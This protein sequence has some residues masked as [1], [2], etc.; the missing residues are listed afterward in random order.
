MGI[1]MGLVWSW[2]GNKELA[3]VPRKTCEAHVKGITIVMWRKGS[4]EKEQSQ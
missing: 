2:A 4:I 1:V 3:Q